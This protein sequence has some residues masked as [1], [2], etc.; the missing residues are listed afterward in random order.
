MAIA[1]LGL[2]NSGRRR[3]SPFSKLII[4]LGII[5]ISGRRQKSTFVKRVSRPFGRDSERL[6]KKDR[7]T[8][9]AESRP[10]PNTPRLIPRGVLNHDRELRLGTDLVGSGQ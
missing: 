3:N 9:L 10:S 7:A 1:S 5:K 4:L 8:I 6:P 2:W